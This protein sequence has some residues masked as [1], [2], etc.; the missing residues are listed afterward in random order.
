MLKHKYLTPKNYTDY[1]VTHLRTSVHSDQAVE[2]LRFKDQGWI[3]WRGLAWLC[4]F[5][6]AAYFGLWAG[7]FDG[8]YFL[9]Q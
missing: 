7:I 8:L 5:A 6:G 9:F 1:N 4:A 3:P 2:I